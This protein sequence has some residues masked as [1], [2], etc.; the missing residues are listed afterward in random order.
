MSAV[1]LFTLKDA[2]AHIDPSGTLTDTSLRT[3]ARRGNLDLR[4]VAGK[5]FVTEADLQGMI[6]RC[7]H[8]ESRLACGSE[9]GQGDQT[10]IS[11]ST[12]G[13]STQ[14]AAAQMTAKG[15]KKLSPTT[16]PESGKRPA[17]PALKAI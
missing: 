8:H 7:L 14:Q 11:S 17:R 4:R 10:P 16:S 2:A 15:L 9:S 12:G 1:R 13:S 5:D 6:E 3:E